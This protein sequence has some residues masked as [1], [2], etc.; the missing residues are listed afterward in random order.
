MPVRFFIE[1]LMAVQ[2]LDL[3]DVYPR[4]TCVDARP[5]WF[6]HDG[7]TFLETRSRAAAAPQT[8]RDEYHWVDVIEGGVSRRVCAA[9]YRHRPPRVIGVWDGQGWAAAPPK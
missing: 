1:R 6:V 7:V 2:G 4:R 9:L 8:E 3:A 5:H